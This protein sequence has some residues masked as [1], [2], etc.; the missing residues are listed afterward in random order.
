MNINLINKEDVKTIEED[1]SGNLQ[2][3]N[4]E[5][6]PFIDKHVN[7]SFSE[8]DTYD[9]SFNDYMNLKDKCINNRNHSMYSNK[10]NFCSG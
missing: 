4:S 1:R 5:H 6:I 8:E 10:N 7:F 3:E 9:K 2:G